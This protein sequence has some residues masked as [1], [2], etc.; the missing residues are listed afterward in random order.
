MTRGAALR[1]SIRNRQLLPLTP[2]KP[3]A[4]T[5]NEAGHKA[6]QQPAHRCECRRAHDTTP[7]RKETP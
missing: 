1:H 3:P 2:P 4:R 7:R 6:A 5:L